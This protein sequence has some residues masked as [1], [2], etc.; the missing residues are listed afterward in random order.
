VLEFVDLVLVMT[1]N[2]G[3]GGQQIIPRCL[4]KVESLR[5]LR[6]REGRGFLI[7]VDGGINRE[8]VHSA[9]AAGAD[10]IVAGNAVFTSP[11]PK[12]EVAALRGNG[13]PA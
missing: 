4:R 9:L 7:E 2:P 8:T 11:D 12:G 3:F 1:V 6:E 13:A 5:M 10:V